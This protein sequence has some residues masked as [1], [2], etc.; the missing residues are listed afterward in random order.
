MPF[1]FKKL[2][3]KGLILIE[4]KVFHDDRGHF[5]EMF[6]DSDFKANG[7]EDRFLQDNFSF[8]KKNVLRGL[9]YQKFPHFQSKLV[10]CL[11]GKIFDVAVDI[12]KDSPTFG[13]HFSIVLSEENHK[14]LYIPEGFAHGFY[15]LE[16]NSLILYKSS[17]EYH[18]QADSGI[19]WNDPSLKIDWP[20]QS[21]PLL[22]EK[23]KIQPTFVQ[24]F[25]G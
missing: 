25:G 13:Q 12:R 8:S 9:H 7:I 20:L 16:D 4:P 18:P 11:R 2:P 21:D 10:H 14:L 24:V 19:I 3:I 5:L 17:K 6:K 1:T 23:D 15:T 22:S